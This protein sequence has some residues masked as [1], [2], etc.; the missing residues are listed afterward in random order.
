MAGY[1]SFP[2]P[3]PTDNPYTGAASGFASSAASIASSLRAAANQHAQMQQSAAEKAAAQKHQD[4]SDLATALKE[5]AVPVSAGAT[6]LPTDPATRRPTLAQSD[7]TTS[8]SPGYGARNQ[9][10]DYSFD[11]SRIVN[12][13]GPPVYY[14]TEEEKAAVS[15]KAKKN[16]EPQ[17]DTNSFPL[18][19]I[20]TAAMN[21]YYGDGTFK[22]GQ[23]LPFAQASIATEAVK[24]YLSKS[25]LNDTNSLKVTKE[26]AV[27][28][29]A[30]GIEIDEGAR[31]PIE[32]ASNAIDLA[33]IAFPP[34]DK[35][36]ATQIIPG[37]VGP[38]GGPLILDKTKQSASELTLPAGSK[39]QETPAQ[40]DTRQRHLDAQADRQ[41]ARDQR[42]EDQAQK[43]RDAAQKTIDALQTKEQEQHA[44]R[45]AYGNVL[46]TKDGDEFVDPD[47]R[48]SPKMNPL[49]RQFYQD[50]YNKATTLAGSYADQ[51]KKLIARNG[52]G[53][54]PAADAPRSAKTTPLKAAPAQ[55]KT[56]H[57]VGDSVTLKSGKT[58]KI[59]KINPDGTFEGQ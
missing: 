12:R 20:T 19:K 32:H 25:A 6:D 3:F 54:Q 23:R 53:N 48:D 28:L 37:M 46:A 47:T 43:G 44:K 22:E 26:A 5:G 45:Q 59:S 24:A 29:K 34:A 56:G 9:N 31:I 1:P 16:A 14:P 49:R 10:P 50:R 38:G 35:P 33:K 7:A 30:Q 11:P 2:S 18:S 41:D 4:A 15:A 40:Q 57:K 8:Q 17:D 51:Q 58:V 27:R 13:G 21:A 39:Q 55:L 42:R 36:D 52:G